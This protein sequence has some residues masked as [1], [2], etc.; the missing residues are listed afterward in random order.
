MK[1]DSNCYPL[2][3]TSGISWIGNVPRHWKLVR[4]RTILS[5][6]TERNRSDLPLLSVVREKGVI[7]RDVD[8]W[9][10]NPNFI[11]DDLS[12]YKVVGKGQFAMNKMKAWQGSYGVSQYEGI[13][14]PAYFVFDVNEVMADYFH[15]AVR[16]KAFVPFFRQASDGVR[17]G[18]WDLSQTRMREIPF[19]VPPLPEQAAIVR[20]LDQIGDCI[21]RYVNAKKRLIRLLAE[22]KQAVIDHAVTRGL[23]RD[24]PSKPSG[25]E[26]IGGVPRHWGFK[27]LGHIATKF[28]SGITPRGGSTVYRECGV[29]FLRSQN[30]HFDGLRIRD[31]ARIAPSLHRELSGTHVKPGDVLLNITGASIGRVCSVPDDFAEANVNQHVCIIRPA[32]D[33]IHPTLL[34]AFLSTTMMQREIQFEQSGASREGLTIQSIRNFRVIV[35]PLSE[36]SC[37]VRYLDKTTARIEATIGRTRRQIELIEKYRIRLIA[38]VVTG[39]LDVREAAVNLSDE[40]GDLGSAGCS[41]N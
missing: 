40:V 25:V 23:D 37:I 14:S 24:V 19:W 26:S 3:S 21:N 30:I 18:Q 1:C 22:K 5:E 32:Q 9:D 15:V 11:P 27:R 2:T 6:K 16:S 10:E 39:K 33:H 31:V 20:Y 36:Q 41:E 34:A 28:G 13:V 12:N 8:N 7:L 38:D 17:I 35:P 4:F 29:P